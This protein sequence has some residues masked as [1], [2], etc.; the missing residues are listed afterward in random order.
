MTKLLVGDVLQGTRLAWAGKALDLG[1]S[2]GGV[3]LA[4]FAVPLL[5]P[6]HV[7]RRD[8]VAR[9]MDGEVAILPVTEEQWVLPC[10]HPLTHVAHHFGLG[11]RSRAQPTAPSGG[12]D[13][14]ACS[15]GNARETVTPCRPHHPGLSS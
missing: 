12:P 13:W 8:P 15:G 7:L 14:T 1:R 9:H 10:P 4:P 11:E 6:C 2:D 5:R 3:R